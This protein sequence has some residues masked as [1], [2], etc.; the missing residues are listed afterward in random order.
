MKKCKDYWIYIVLCVVFIAIRVVPLSIGTE[1]DEAINDIAI[2]GFAST[3]VA[4]IIKIN[5]DRANKKRK[6]ALGCRALFE[7]YKS[8]AEYMDTFVRCICIQ[9]RIVSK[10]KNNT[11]VKWN[12]EL[13]LDLK[14]VDDVTYEALCN[15]M[16]NLE[17]HANKILSQQDW[18]VSEGIL[19]VNIIETIGKLANVFLMK[20][21]LLKGTAGINN[22]QIMNNELIDCLQNSN[23]LSLS[24]FVTTEYGFSNHMRAHINSDVLKVEV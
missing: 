10:E 7:L 14:E 15:F 22:L 16:D 20:E 19:D 2:G 5:D 1:Y 24:E 9:S 4:L 21:I 17:R 3:L 18:Y 6:N 12:E 23:E 11:F 8:I 13:S